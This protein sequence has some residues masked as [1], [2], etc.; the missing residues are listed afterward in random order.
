[1]RAHRTNVKKNAGSENTSPKPI[2]IHVYLTRY[3]DKEKILK[4]A[5]S[6]LKNNYYKD[7]PISIS[8]NVSKSVHEDC[9]T[10]RKSYLADIKAKPNMIFTFI[11]WS[12]PVQI[13]YK[14]GA[15]K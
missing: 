15:D 1:M 2:Q 10:L 5:P 12:V 8:D 6:Q 4:M 13:L 11:A 7:L 3:T 9:T 14:E